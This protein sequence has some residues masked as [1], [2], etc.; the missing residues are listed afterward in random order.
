MSFSG[1]MSY[2]MMTVR[3][4]LGFVRLVERAFL[5]GLVDCELEGGDLQA[6]LELICPDFKISYTQVRWL[7]I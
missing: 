3:N 1:E 6:F 7:Y 5:P 2:V 4:R